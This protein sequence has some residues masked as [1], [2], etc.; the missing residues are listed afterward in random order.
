[1][2]VIAAESL[3][4]LFFNAR[5]YSKWLDKPVESGLLRELVNIM[6]F[7]PTSVNCQPIRVLFLTNPE[8][9]QR[10]LPALDAGNVEKTMQAP[11]TAILGYDLAFYE[12]LPFLF[13]HADARSWFVGNEALSFNTAFRNGSLQAAYF[14]LAARA[15]GLDCG[16]MSG[17]NNP[18]VDEVFFADSTIRSNFL[19]NLGYGD[20]AALHPRLPRPEFD[21]ICE[22]L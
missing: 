11:V 20:A 15:V 10:L 22:I 8:A 6:R 5:T 4:T 21:D 2:S 16:P 1:M 7:G 19:C 13:P 17:F 18:M 12:Q 14:M 3:N 9:K